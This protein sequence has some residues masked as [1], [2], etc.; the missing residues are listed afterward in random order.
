ME[1]EVDGVDSWKSGVGVDKHHRENAVISSEAAES[2]VVA[3][4]VL[5]DGPEGARGCGERGGGAEDLSAVKP[6]CSDSILLGAGGGSR[7][8]KDDAGPGPG[9]VRGVG[10]VDGGRRE[11]NCVGKVM[12][13]SEHRA[14]R[15]LA[16]Q[17]RRERRIEVPK[18]DIRRN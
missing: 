6:H 4:D 2:G 14:F 5:L 11:A 1:G 9:A 10:V 16:R 7:E 13:E 3:G 8:L 12:A 18:G 15:L 17:G